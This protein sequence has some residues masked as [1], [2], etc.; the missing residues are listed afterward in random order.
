MGVQGL[1]QLLQPT[2]RPVTL[3]SLNGKVLAVGMQS[4]QSDSLLCGWQRSV[5]VSMLAS[6][7]VVN[8][9]WARLLLEWVTACGQINRLGI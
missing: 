1:W 5:V 6:I 8:R 2:G 7:N 4:D 9:H 3:E